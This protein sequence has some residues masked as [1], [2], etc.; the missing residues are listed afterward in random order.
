MTCRIIDSWNMTKFTNCKI[1]QEIEFLIYINLFGLLF[2]WQ[3][4]KTPKLWKHTLITKTQRPQGAF[5]LFPFPKN[6]F[7]SRTTYINTHIACRWIFTYK[8]FSLNKMDL[9]LGN[10]HNTPSLIN[11]ELDNLICWLF[12]VTVCLIH[13]LWKWW[14][15]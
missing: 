7:K 9:L 4:V 5:S 3:I 1:N 15:P 13:W 14:L 10:A 11:S 8:L 12:P 2:L 6:T